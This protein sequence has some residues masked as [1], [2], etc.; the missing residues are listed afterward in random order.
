MKRERTQ[1]NF[2][3]LLFEYFELEFYFESDYLWDDL[4]WFVQVDLRKV[5]S[6]LKAITGRHYQIDTLAGKE[7]IMYDF[8][9]GF[10]RG[11][12]PCTEDQIKWLR[13]LFKN[14][15]LFNNL[16]GE[17]P[18]ID[19]FYYEIYIS[20]KA[21]YQY[22]TSFEHYYHAV[23]TPEYEIIDAFKWREIDSLIIEKS[24]VLLKGMIILLGKNFE[25]IFSTGEL[26]A[27]YAYP[28]VCNSQVLDAK[29]KY[30]TS[31]CCN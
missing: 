14:N 2:S 25:K 10:G 21:G 11:A 30:F 17:K 12:Q 31:S 1:W 26:I 6:A 5:E 16:K 18:I 20:Y 27:N 19:E 23:I 28:A 4:P 22:I 15:R 3:T 13:E 7:E 29:K 8:Y 24:E 9:H